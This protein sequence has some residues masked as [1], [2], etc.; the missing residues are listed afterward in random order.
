[1]KD[2]SLQITFANAQTY[3]NTLE[4]KDVNLSLSTFL[5]LI[6]PIRILVYLVIRLLF[7][8]LLSRMTILIQHQK[9]CLYII[10]LNLIQRQDSLPQFQPSRWII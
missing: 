6:V 5:L 7:H 8:V 9:H 10:N 3:S 2:T 4:L 1:M